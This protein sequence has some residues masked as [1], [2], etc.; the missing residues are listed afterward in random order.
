[1]NIVLINPA[2]SRICRLSLD[3]KSVWKTRAGKF[4]VTLS[5]SGTLPDGKTISAKA[6]LKGLSEK[7]LEYLNKE[8]APLGFIPSHAGFI[9]RE[10]DAP[11]I[12]NVLLDRENSALG[13]EAYKSLFGA[14]RPIRLTLTVSAPKPNKPARPAGKGDADF[15]DADPQT[16]SASIALIKG[17]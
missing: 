1:M 13:K 11:S 6:A 5:A 4:D 8:T 17:K 15:R 9:T 14:V 3:T 16:V 12:R 7:G 2:D 10:E